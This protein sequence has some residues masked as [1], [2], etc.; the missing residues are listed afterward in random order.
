MSMLHLLQQLKEGAEGQGKHESACE[1]TGGAQ[2]NGNVQ[3]WG[4]L[5]VREFLLHKK[6][7]L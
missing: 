1:L 5:R 6:V 7:K 2:R 4:V 3:A